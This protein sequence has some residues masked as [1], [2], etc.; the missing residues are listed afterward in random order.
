MTTDEVRHY[1]AIYERAA[2]DNGFLPG[3]RVGAQSRVV[4]A[5]FSIPARSGRAAR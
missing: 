5:A 2:A 4:L 3:I 1:V